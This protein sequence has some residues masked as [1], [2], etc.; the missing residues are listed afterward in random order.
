MRVARRAG[1][2]KDLN[3]VAV[4]QRRG[5]FPQSGIASKLVFQNLTQLRHDWPFPSI[6]S[7][8][9]GQAVSSIGSLGH[10]VKEQKWIT[11]ISR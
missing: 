2:K 11:A 5:Q 3:H 6:V 4:E 8:S 1:G 10:S 9:T 7:R